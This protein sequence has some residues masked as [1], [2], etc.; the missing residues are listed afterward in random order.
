MGRLTQDRLKEILDYDPVTGIF[1]WNTSR[2]KCTK[3][4][5]AGCIR[6]DG[7]RT[8]KVDGIACFASRL[9]WLFMEGYSPENQMDHINRIR[10]DERWVNLRHVSSQ[11]NNRNSSNPK[12]NTSGVAGV[13]WF[14]VSN[15]WRS[16]IGIDK[17]SMHLGLFKTLREA[18]Q[19][20][21]KAE[22]EHDWPG[23]NSHT[24]AYCYL[25]AG[26]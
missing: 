12:N 5:Q 13:S 26:L 2:K 8:I 20:R 17:K 21:W 15:S 3:G 19:A 25:H 7:Y 24:D 1:T 16:R 22:V 4:K 6:P 11:C 14:N 18:V 9:A 10:A 23:C